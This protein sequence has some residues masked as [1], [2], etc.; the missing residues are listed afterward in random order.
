MAGV[1]R[2]LDISAFD[3]GTTFGPQSFPKQDV[4]STSTAQKHALGS[5]Y[6]EGDR[7]FRYSLNGA[8]ALSK[9]LMTQTKVVDD[10]TDDAI[11]NAASTWAVG[12][13]S[14][15]LLVT[16][17][18][19]YA[20]NEFAD[21]WFYA[22]KI[23]GVGDIYRV[24]ASE[25]DSTDTI[26]RIELDTPIRTAISAT[27]EITLHANKYSKVV[28]YPLT[29]TGVA[30]GV[31]LVAVAASEYFWAQTAGPCPVIVDDGESVQIGEKV[32]APGA[33]AD[34]GACGVWVTL[35]QTWG[36]VLHVGVTDEPALID[37]VLE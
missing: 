23:A 17:G 12:D 30:T 11:Q 5:R 34:V 10:K 32:G 22:N 21:G 36:N 18:G 6:V 35:T 29:V 16:T 25:L 3:R 2:Q 8:G 13:V 14:G 33:Y 24:I 15:Q 31:P 7:V 9:A 26:L 19:G 1:R 27:T 20:K 4:Y 28:V 37:L